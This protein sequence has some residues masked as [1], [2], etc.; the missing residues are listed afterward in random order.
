MG[1]QIPIAEEYFFSCPKHALR[2]ENAIVSNERFK[3]IV[4]YSAK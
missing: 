2:I 4:M 1:H 3:T